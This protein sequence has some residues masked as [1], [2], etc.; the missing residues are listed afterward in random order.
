METFERRNQ[1]A[2]D[3]FDGGNV[4]RCR[5]CVVRG[6]A[7]IDMIVRVDGVAPSS[8]ARG[9]FIGSTSNHFVGVHVGR[10]ARTCLI[11]V[12]DKLIGKLSFNDFV[13]SF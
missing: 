7:P 8:F 9:D 2:V 13:G 3:G 12:H 5:N 10:R 4:N 11:H 6:L 1:M